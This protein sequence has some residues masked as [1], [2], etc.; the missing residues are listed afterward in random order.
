MLQPIWALLFLFSAQPTGAGDLFFAR[1][2]G[3]ETVARV[4]EH[5]VLGP[6]IQVGF[7][8]HSVRGR[9]W[10]AKADLNWDADRVSGQFG[11]LRVDLKYRAEADG[12]LTMDGVFAG[13]AIH[14]DLSTTTITG[15]IGTRHLALT[16]SEGVFTGDGLEIDIPQALR[17]RVAGEQA[18]VLPLLLAGVTRATQSDA[19]L[20]RVAPPAGWP[21]QETA[22]TPS[23]F[24]GGA[25]GPNVNVRPEVDPRR[26]M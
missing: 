6:A 24:G 20:F 16:G 25:G 13:S 8:G 18:A 23:A 10:G 11:G 7:L 19:H 2:P 9:A 26:H 17:A 3:N 21:T 22:V 12:H 15:H 1:A 14:L 5:N 4:F